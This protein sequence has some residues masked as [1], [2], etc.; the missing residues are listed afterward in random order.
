M[1][2]VTA[3]VQ[4]NIWKLYALQ[5]CYEAMFIIPVLI[6]FFQ[7]N[8]VTIKQVF[9]LQGVFALVC[10]LA[11]I[12]TG[13]LSDRWG[14]KKT[15]V[16]GSVFGLLGMVAYG[17]STN[18]TG[19]LIG[20]V[21]LALL[22][23]FHSGA[24]QALMYDTLLETGEIPLYRRVAGR[25]SVLGFMAQAI[26]SVLGGLMAVYSLRMTVWATVVPFAIGL[27][28]TFFLQEPRR[29]QLREER[30]LDVMWRVAKQTLFHNVP[31]RSM[32]MLSSVVGTLTLMLMWF[33]Q[34]YQELIHLPLAWFG[35]THAT[36]MISGAL[37][38]HIAI[39]AERWLDDRMLLL[40]IAGLI[41]GSYLGLGLVASFWGMPLLLLGR[42]MWGAIIPVTN[43][44][45]NRMTGSDIRA[46]ML[47]VQSFASRLVAGV[48]LLAVGYAAEVLTL[49]G[50]ILLTG[51]VGAIVL[52]A[53]FLSMRNVWAKIPR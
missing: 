49:N 13:Y 42:S 45:M 38:S 1:K 19:F 17:L 30:H 36:M 32:V 22:V 39:S 3:S 50:A 26:V 12:P 18:F 44:L 20:E 21:L 53:L 37:A 7:D 11:E 25:Q 5:V 23:S 9:F 4:S 6:P 16:A 29:H 47:S 40:V 10:M 41:I 24:V 33:S 28:L 15:I 43:D 14:R 52:L 34:P 51:G 46:T 8:G 35:L 31:L 48:S 2:T 27:V